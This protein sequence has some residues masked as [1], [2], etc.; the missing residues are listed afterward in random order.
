[1]TVEASTA[2]PTPQQVLMPSVIDTRVLLQPAACDGDRTKWA[3]WAFTFGAYASAVS[4]SHG[5]LDGTPSGRDR[6]ARLA[7]SAKRQQ[8]QRTVAPRARNARG[9]RSHEEGSKRTCG[10]RQLDRLLCEEYE[11]RQIRRFQA[12]VSAILRV[13]LREPLAECLRRPA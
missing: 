8:G 10:S 3:D 1:M 7:H 2:T 5:R 9:G 6:T 13:Q 4:T 12:M 11:P